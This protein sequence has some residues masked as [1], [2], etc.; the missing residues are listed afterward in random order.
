VPLAPQPG[1]I[2]LRHNRGNTT[3]HQSGEEVM[4]QSHNPCLSSLVK[5][6]SRVKTTKIGGMK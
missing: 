6:V 4:D 2:T 1:S 3:F 5:N